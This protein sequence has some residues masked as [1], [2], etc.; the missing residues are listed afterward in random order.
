MSVGLNS[1][2]IPPRRQS[3]GHRRQ[4]LRMGDSSG[5]GPA[6]APRWRI[7][8]FWVSCSGHE[9]RWEQT[10]LDPLSS[11]TRRSWL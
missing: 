9:T 11:F 8:Y 5:A 3:G 1:S 2:T 10:F 7:L 6:G 4:H